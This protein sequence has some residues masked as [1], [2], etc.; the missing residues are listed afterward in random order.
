MYINT[1]LYLGNLE[2]CNHQIDYNLRAK[3]AENHRYAANY[4][5]YGYYITQGF[6]KQLSSK[7]IFIDK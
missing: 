6:L 2:L 4:A 1:N 7:Y 3:C 5:C